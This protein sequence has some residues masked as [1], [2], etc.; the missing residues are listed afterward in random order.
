[1]TRKKTLLKLVNYFVYAFGQRHLHIWW[2]AMPYVNF[3]KIVS[4]S[5]IDVVEGGAD[6]EYLQLLKFVE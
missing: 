5:I 3:D 2:A 4:N 6:G 1:M